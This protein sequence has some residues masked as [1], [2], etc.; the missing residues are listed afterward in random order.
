MALTPQFAPDAP[1]FVPLNQDRVVVLRPQR[2][3]GAPGERLAVTVY[4][5]GVDGAVTEG[6]VRWQAGSAS[7]EIAAPGGLIDGPLAAAW[8]AVAGTVIA[9]NRVEFAYVSPSIP[10]QPISIL[11]DDALAATLRDL[12]YTVVNEAGPDVLLIAHHY[13][14]QLETALSENVIAQALLKALLPWP[15]V[16]TDLAR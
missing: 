13:T 11:N 16:S 2:W 15:Q 8:L 14:A 4:T 3:S 7:G 10:A 6:I 1:H 12:G 9:K 5:S